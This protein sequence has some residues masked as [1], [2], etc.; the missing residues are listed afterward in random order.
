MHS[1][2]WFFPL[3]ALITIILLLLALLLLISPQTS[4]KNKRIN[5]FIHGQA[6]TGSMIQTRHVL[7]YVGFILH[8]PSTCVGNWVGSGIHT[9]WEARECTRGRTMVCQTM[10]RFGIRILGSPSVTELWGQA[11]HQF[12]RVHF[13]CWKKRKLGE[14]T[15]NRG[16]CSYSAKEDIRQ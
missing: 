10:S 15:I 6:S 13:S 4:Q 12:F 16:L 5:A 14:M 1:A 8:T 11:T 2:I 7:R 9:D 3:L